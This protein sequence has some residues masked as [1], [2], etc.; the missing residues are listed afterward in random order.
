MDEIFLNFGQFFFWGFVQKWTIGPT[1]DG[2]NMG[3]VGLAKP[4]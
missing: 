4:I 2:Q 1:F 3:T